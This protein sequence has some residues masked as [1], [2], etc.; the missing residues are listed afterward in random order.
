MPAS[1]ASRRCELEPA[2]VKQSQ[3]HGERSVA[4][5]EKLD[6]RVLVYTRTRKDGSIPVMASEAWPSR[7]I[8]IAAS[9]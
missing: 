3:R 5:W 4:I 9:S 8:W 2:K 6:C 1:V 7:I